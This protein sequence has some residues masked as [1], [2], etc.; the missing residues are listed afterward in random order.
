MVTKTY[1]FE[2]IRIL[3]VGSHDDDLLHLVSYFWNLSLTLPY[4]AQDSII[5][6]VSVFRWRMGSHLPIWTW[7][8]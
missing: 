2:G 7:Q 4:R 5:G 6:C 1:T 8:L 3:I